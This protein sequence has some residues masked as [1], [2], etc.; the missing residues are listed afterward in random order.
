M[1]SWVYYA[2]GW[3]MLNPHTAPSSGRG[4]QLGD[5]LL[6]DGLFIYWRVDQVLFQQAEVLLNDFW[7]Q[8]SKTGSALTAVCRILPLRKRP[9]GCTGTGTGS[10][11]CLPD[12]ARSGPFPGR[13]PLTLLIIRS[14]SEPSNFSQCRPPWSGSGS[15]DWE[16]TF[17]RAWTT[18]T[19]VYPSTKKDASFAERLA[20][21]QRI[22]RRGKYDCQ[23][24]Y[25]CVEPPHVMERNNPP[26]VGKR[27]EKLGDSHV[28]TTLFPHE[29]FLR[30]VPSVDHH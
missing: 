8:I 28:P 12:Q 3:R 9:H 6:A 16:L 1:L 17:M 22:A 10:C 26:V 20:I 25:E 24:K 11:L 2:A 23:V 19:D 15:G 5:V 21:D 13:M 30:H 7:Q 29:P 27:E 14:S 4:E 18:G